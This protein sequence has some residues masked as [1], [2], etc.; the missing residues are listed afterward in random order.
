MQG[1]G[2]DVSHRSA[3]EGACNGRERHHLLDVDPVRSAQPHTERL[4][5][6]LGFQAIHSQPN[7]TTLSTT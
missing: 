1:G 5:T 2:R 6:Q 3:I 7:D 4:A